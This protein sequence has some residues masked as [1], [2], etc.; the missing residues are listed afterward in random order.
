MM[1]MGLLCHFVSVY[2]LDHYIPSIDLVP[3]LNEF[4]DVF[5]DDLPVILLPREI[6][7]GT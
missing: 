4:Q 6:Y 5:P 1:S 7:F 2:N 3:L